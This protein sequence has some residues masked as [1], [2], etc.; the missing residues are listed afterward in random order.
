MAL[1]LLA[2]FAARR[3]KKRPY[4]SGVNPW[5]KALAKISLKLSEMVYVRQRLLGMFLERQKWPV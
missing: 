3:K 5:V 1:I 2:F 4:A